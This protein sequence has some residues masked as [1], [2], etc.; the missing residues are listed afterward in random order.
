MINT[1]TTYKDLEE[2]LVYIHFG[3]I[4]YINPKTI[5]FKVGSLGLS[6]I[7]LAS[8]LGLHC[9]SGLVLGLLRINM[10]L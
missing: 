9:F 5:S 1:W 10:V 3:L 7:S 6:L 2:T 8:D 4:V